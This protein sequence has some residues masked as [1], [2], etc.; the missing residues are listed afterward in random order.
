MKVIFRPEICGLYDII[1]RE[2]TDNIFRET[3][4]VHFIEICSIEADNFDLQYYENII[5]EEGHYWGLDDFSI[6][7]RTDPKVHEIMKDCEGIKIIEVPD[8]A[9]IYIYSDDDGSES[10]HE[11]HRVWR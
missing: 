10:I 3:G 11:E 4:L 6:D 7:F 9:K 5:I 2:I 8:S 1:I